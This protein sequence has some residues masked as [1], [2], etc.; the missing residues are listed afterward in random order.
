MKLIPKIFPGKKGKQ[1]RF[2]V[3]DIGLGRVN[4]AIFEVSDEG[5]KFI[6]VGRRSFTE[7]DT[8]LD[9]TLEATD[10]LGAIVDEL[11]RPAIIG[12]SDGKMSTVSTNAKY[13]REK[14]DKIVSKEEIA[15]VM[16]KV[17]SEEKEGLKVFFST[18]TG[19]KIDDQRVTNP[20]GIKGEKAEVNC[21]VAYKPESELKVYEKIIDDLEV[22]PE[23]ILPTSFAVYQMLSKKIDGDFL[24]LRVGQYKSEAA[25]VHSGQLIQINNFDLGAE[26]MEFYPLALEA[27]LEKQDEDKRSKTI[28]LY[29]DSD[30]IN[31]VDVK[32]ALSEVSWKEKLRLKEEIKIEQAESENNFGPADMGLLALSLQ[33]IFNK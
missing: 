19:A 8:I 30:E 25:E 4:L 23:K 12:V 22:K 32:E 5:P 11:P 1:S 18:V 29:S 28:W 7:A 14:K 2:V 15:D 9:A 13:S 21:F 6:G 16:N 20:I 26:Q 10:A 24:I 17:T 3:V 27:L 33:E 31:L